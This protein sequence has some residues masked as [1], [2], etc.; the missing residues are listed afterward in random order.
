[1]PKFILILALVFS[2]NA[3]DSP[4][5]ATT[6][7]ALPSIEFSDAALDFESGQPVFSKNT[8]ATLKVG[9]AEDVKIY[10]NNEVETQINNSQVDL[11]S[12]IEFSEG[13]Y[14]VLVKGENF[15]EAFGFTIR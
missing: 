14:T 13:T 4:K 2:E 3:I 6:I 15:E 8:T 9:T 11:T 5:S 1:M 7:E 12:L 10:I